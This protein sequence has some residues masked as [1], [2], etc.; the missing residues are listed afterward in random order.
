M[1]TG[2]LIFCGCFFTV[3]AKA[4]S[5]NLMRPLPS[6]S[7]LL[8]EKKKPAFTPII[9]FKNYSINPLGTQPAKADLP[10]IIVQ[11]NIDEI[12]SSSLDGMGILIPNKKN[13]S[14]MPIAVYRENKMLQDS[15]KRR[16]IPENATPQLLPNFPLPLTEREMVPF[17]K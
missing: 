2:L 7:P 6:I 10:K 13:C 4:Q 5:E 8:K 16:M 17:N 12:Y 3:M 14:N 9:P 1:K 15:L 11:S